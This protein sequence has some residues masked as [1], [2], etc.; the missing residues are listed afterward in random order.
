MLTQLL[1]LVVPCYNESK[2]IDFEYFDKIANIVGVKLLFVDDG[3][4]DN[5]LNMIESYSSNGKAQYL[6]LKKNKGKA[7]AIRSG[8]QHLHNLDSEIDWVGFIDADQ[9]FDFETVR[10][11]IAL[12]PEMEFN[13][14]EAIYSS[15]VKLLGRSIT[16]KNSR[17]Y[18]S[19]VISTFFGLAWVTIPYDTQSGFK[20]YKNTRE[21]RLVFSSLEFKTRW[22]FDIE[23]HIE[24]C[25][26][27]GRNLNGWEYPVHSW[28]DIQGS[29]ITKFEK[30]RICYEILTIL[31]KIWSKRRLLSKMQ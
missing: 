13:G 9:A 12:L 24:L 21:F 16:R 7:S 23:T 26:A 14:V 28:Q 1:F 15:R 27:Y 29:R 17:H 10:E 4:R 20:L 18:L 6:A 31:S 22:F 8:I 11:M 3:S 2:R 5:T 25:K 30:L 19:R